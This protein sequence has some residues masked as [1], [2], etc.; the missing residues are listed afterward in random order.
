MKSDITAA[1]KHRH[2]AE[3]QYLKYPTILKKQQFKKAKY[4][5]EEWCIKQILNF[6]YLKLP[7]WLQKELFAACNKLI[8]LKKLSDFPNIYLVDQ[9]SAIFSLIGLS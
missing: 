9:M 2:L 5:I 7:Q 6:I 4:S 1:K 3:R 8:G